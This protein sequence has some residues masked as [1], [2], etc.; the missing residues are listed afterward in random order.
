MNQIIQIRPLR[1]W[2]KI[3]GWM[4]YPL[5]RWLSGAPDEEPR[6]TFWLTHDEL[7]AEQASRLDPA[8]SVICL[9]DE[10]A[11]DRF[12]WGFIPQFMAARFGGWDKYAVLQP[13]RLLEDWYVGWQAPDVSGLSLVRSKGPCRVLL[14]PFETSFFGLNANGEQINIQKVSIGQ[15]GDGGH[16]CLT[17]FL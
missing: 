1:W 17:P 10:S 7:S 9:G 4:L 13:D 5:M 15:T 8:K 2:V 12:L 16:Y 6:Q 14:G 3:V 11:C